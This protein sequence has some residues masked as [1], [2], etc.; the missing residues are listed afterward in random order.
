M[1]TNKDTAVKI[2]TPCT[3][4]CRLI[5]D[6]YCSG[7]QRT[8]KQIKNWT[9]YTEKERLAIMRELKKKPVDKLIM[10]W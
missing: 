4:K 9:I 8:W 5:N 2:S 6:S 3:R 7:C 1:I 10:N